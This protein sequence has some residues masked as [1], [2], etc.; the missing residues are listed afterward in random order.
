[1]T[2]APGQHLARSLPPRTSLVWP[3]PVTRTQSYAAV[4][5]SSTS[6]L[7]AGTAQGNL[8]TQSNPSIDIQWDGLT[9]RSDCRPA[10][11]TLYL[12]RQ[13]STRAGCALPP[14][15]LCSRPQR[16]THLAS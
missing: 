8:D 13:R 1:M 3:P 6:A 12:R 11:W 4:V 9:A 2:P 10:P 7:Q 15:K 16:G 14:R 5:T